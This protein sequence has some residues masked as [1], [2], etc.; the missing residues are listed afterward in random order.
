MISHG[1][2]VIDGTLPSVKSRFGRNSVQI[3][4]EGDGGFMR[5]L[6]GVKRMTEFNNYVELELED[7]RRAPDILKDVVNRVRVFR[8]EVMEPSLYD[9]FIDMAKVD[10]SELQGGQEV[11]HV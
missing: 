5:G 6:A 1:K 4:F 8:F 10:P 3:A 9:I 7:A 11:G 2:K